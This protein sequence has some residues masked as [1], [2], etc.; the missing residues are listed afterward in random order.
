MMFKIACTKP[1]ENDNG[2][3]TYNHSREGAKLFSSVPRVEKIYALRIDKR[4]E[5]SNYIIITSP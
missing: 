3:N 4:G 5:G 2:E 1:H